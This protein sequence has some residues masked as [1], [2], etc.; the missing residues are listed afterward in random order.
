MDQFR[1]YD[2]EGN[3]RGKLSANPYDPDF[4]SN[5]FGQYGSPFFGEFIY[6]PYGAGNS[7]R[8]DSPNNPYGRGWSIEGR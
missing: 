4:T 5:H 6:T 2:Q 8:H 7:F 3:C 1:L